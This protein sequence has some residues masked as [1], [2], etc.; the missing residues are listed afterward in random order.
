M[1]DKL[2]AWASKGRDAEEGLMKDMNIRENKFAFGC[3]EFCVTSVYMSNRSDCVS[4]SDT[5]HYKRK[6]EI[7]VM[8]F[9]R[10][11]N[12]SEKERKKKNVYVQH[13]LKINKFINK[14]HVFIFI[15]RLMMIVNHLCS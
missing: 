6:Q 10:R 2:L 11:L 8:D 5:L 1:T 13:G 15:I 9:Q 14:K 12:Q 3:F 7:S 4:C